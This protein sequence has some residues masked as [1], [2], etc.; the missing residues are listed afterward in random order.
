MKYKFTPEAWEAGSCRVITRAGKKV[1]RF[2]RTST[3]FTGIVDGYHLNWAD[4]GCLRD[5]TK[6]SYD[7]FLIPQSYFKQIIKSILWK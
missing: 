6:H 5:H 3:G 4:N 1:N 7:L 2:K